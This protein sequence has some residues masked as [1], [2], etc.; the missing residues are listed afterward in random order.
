MNI[1]DIIKDYIPTK[2][3]INYGYYMNIK[4]YFQIARIN[5]DKK[6]IKMMIQK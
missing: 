3:F 1:K 5:D 2:E 6:Y 4:Q